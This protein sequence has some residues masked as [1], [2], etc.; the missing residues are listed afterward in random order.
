MA[1]TS[2]PLAPARQVFKAV[3]PMTINVVTSEIRFTVN[4][5]TKLKTDGQEKNDLI[6]SIIR[7][8]LEPPLKKAFLNS[9][10]CGALR[11]LP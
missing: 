11:R 1:G 10:T 4:D 6:A 3:H 5:G 8:L 2:R 7:Q 9:R